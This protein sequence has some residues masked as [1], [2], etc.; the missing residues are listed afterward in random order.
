MEKV[1]HLLPVEPELAEP[2]KGI[3]V[4]ATCLD[5]FVN[6]ITSMNLYGNQGNN[7]ETLNLGQVA[8]DGL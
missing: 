7:L 4:G 2:V 5:Q 8:S 3:L 1:S 6:D